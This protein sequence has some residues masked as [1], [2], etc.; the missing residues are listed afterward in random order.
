[1]DAAAVTR[2]LRTL[3]LA[4]ATALLLL[5]AAAHPAP[6]AVGQPAPGFRLVDQDGRR[7][8]LSALRGQKVVLV[9]YRGFW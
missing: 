1:M 2:A 4:F 9:F 3:S 6:P 7:V 8:E 5:R